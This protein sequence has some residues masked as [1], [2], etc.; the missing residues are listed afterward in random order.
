MVSFGVSRFRNQENRAVERKDFTGTN[1][2]KR[3]LKGYLA[4]VSEFIADYCGG[5]KPGGRRRSSK[6]AKLILTVEPDKVALF[7]LSE[8]VRAVYEDVA[9]VEVSHRIGMMVEDELKFTKFELEKPDLFSALQRDLDSRNSESY[10]HRHRVLTHSMRSNE[11]EWRAWDNETMVGVGSLLLSLTLDATD[12]VYKETIR[13]GRKQRVVLRATQEVKDWIESSDEALAV[14]MPDRMPCLMKPEDW[15]SQYNGGYHLPRLRAN[16]PLVKTRRGFSRKPH[17]ELLAQADMAPV[18]SAVNSV[19]RTPWRVNRRVL[20]AIQAVWLSNT[21]VGMPPS[22]PYEVPPCP[23]TKGDLLSDADKDRLD[24]WKTEAR[25]TYALEKHRQSLVLGVSRT[26]RI[27]EMLKEHKEFYY[28]YQLDFRARLYAATAGVSPQGSD[29]AKGC[30]EF[31]RAKPIGERGIYWLKVHGANKFGEDKCSYDERVAWIDARRDQ[32]LAAAADPVGNRDAWKSA[33]KPFQFLAFCFE[34]AGA[35]EYGPTF[36]SRLPIAL[37]GSCNGLQ[38]FSAMLRDPVGGRAVNLLPAD[39]PSDIYQDV[40][41]V[42]TRKLRAIAT[43]PA[44][45]EK[46]AG[47]RVAAANWLSLFKRLGYDGMPRKASKKPVMTLPYGSTQQACT[48]SLFS[49]YLEQQTDHFPEGTNFKHCIFMSS[50]L[51]E[52]I[53]EVVVA[54]RTAMDWIQKVSGTVAKEGMPLMYTSPLGFPVYQGSRKNDVVRVDSRIGGARMRLNVRV[55]IDEIDSR[56]QRQGS[57]PNLV[58]D[59]DAT[60]LMMCVNA[61][62]A[63]GIEDFAMIHDD[64]GTHACHIDDW[65]RIIREQFVKLHTDHDVLHDFKT[66]LEATTGLELDDTPE[67]GTLDLRKVLSSKYFFG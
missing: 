3:L 47:R 37:D 53:G 52:S 10:R 12:L 7:S 2:G 17:E 45:D 38:H 34:Y 21:G 29:P 14:M 67:R 55:E 62:V 59:T 65:Q 46:E 8:I 18:M 36:R 56:K 23:F 4:Q 16:T 51:W 40:A 20:E 66:A 57:S 11:V 30:L 35:M 27:G 63:E 31:A 33:D 60:H 13:E 6:Y 5:N 15:V 42:A 64:F 24:D 54:A 28:V 61:G 19:Q 22:Q 32:W 26:M 9:V 48:A 58:H 43:G 25:E 50:I 1:G 49:W 44:A 39:A 41:D